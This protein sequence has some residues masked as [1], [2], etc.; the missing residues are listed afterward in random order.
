MYKIV[1]YVKVDLGMLKHGRHQ[2]YMLGVVIRGPRGGLYL[3]DSYG[4]YLLIRGIV[5][6]ETGIRDEEIIFTMGLKCKTINQVED[7]EEATCVKLAREQGW[8][9]FK[10]SK[11]YPKVKLFVNDFDFDQEEKITE[12]S[13]RNVL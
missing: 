13:K 9:Y 12:L 6:H 3:L 2:P 10:R 8:T 4:T 7:S 5:M 11:V 1:G